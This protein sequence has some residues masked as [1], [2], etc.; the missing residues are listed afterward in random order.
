MA[1]MRS[2]AHELRESLGYRTEK[3]RLQ[4]ARAA[5]EH[6]DAGAAG[7]CRHAFAERALERDDGE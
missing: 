7:G 4:L 5:A 2:S 1:S 3:A 6:D